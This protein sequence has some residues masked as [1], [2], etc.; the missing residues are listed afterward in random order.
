ML[1]FSIGH[2]TAAVEAKRGVAIMA[3]NTIPRRESKIA[4]LSVSSITSLG[5]LFFPVSVDVIKGKEFNGF[6]SAW[7]SVMV[8]GT[9]KAAIGRKNRK[10]NGLV[11]FR[12]HLQF[13]LSPFRIEGF[14]V[15]ILFRPSLAR[16][17]FSSRWHRLVRWVAPEHSARVGTEFG[18]PLLILER[19]FTSRADMPMYHGG[20][21][22]TCQGVCQ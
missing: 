1:N 12:R 11:V 9:G 3:E 6:W 5:A 19:L 14:L 16:F 7:F 17:D 2:R 8:T 21:I 22:N 18:N 15:P 4:E 10:A 13:L 20:K